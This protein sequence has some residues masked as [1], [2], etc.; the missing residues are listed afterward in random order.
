MEMRHDCGRMQIILINGTVVTQSDPGYYFTRRTYA[1][2]HN[3]PNCHTFYITD[4]V[5]FQ[6]RKIEFWMC[7]SMFTAQCVHKL[8]EIGKVNFRSIEIIRE[9]LVLT[10]MVCIMNIHWW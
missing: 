3:T 2:T 9:I 6:S 1:R 10:R 7:F 8:R 5:L 4:E